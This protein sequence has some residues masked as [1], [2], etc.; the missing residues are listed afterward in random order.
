MKPRAKAV[1]YVRV[2]GLGQ[3]DGDGP[4]RQRQAIARGAKR[5]RLDLVGEFA[6]LGVSGT[7]EGADRP[8]MANLIASVGALGATVLI[9][10]RADRLARDL[11]VQELTLRSL[12]SLGVR[13]MDAS[14]T[15]LTGATG[16]ATQTLVR[17]LLGAVAQ[18]DRA[19]TVAKLRAARDRK[20]AATGRCEGPKPFGSDPAEADAL[21]A[22]KALAR[23]QPGCDAPT[24][25][26]VATKANE[27]GIRSRSGKPWTRGMV[28][29][30]LK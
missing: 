16:D 30:A 20:R 1:S 28:H 24:L 26:E 13:V 22:L 23:K 29:N 11:V 9:V 27:T 14:G 7:T 12:A 4:E 17:Q 2:S 5:E 21:K 10:E 18:F 8:G 6:D 15:D 25:A 3:R 19:Q